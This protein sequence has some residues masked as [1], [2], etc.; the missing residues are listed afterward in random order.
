[1]LLPKRYGIDMETEIGSAIGATVAVAGRN[2]AGSDGWGTTGDSRTGASSDGGV[3][4]EHA[5]TRSKLGAA[6]RDHVLPDVTRD[7]LTVLRVGVREN[8]LDQV[9]AVLITG[10]VDQGD[11]RTI[12]ATLTNS[13]EVATKEINT[14]NLQ[15]LL[16]NLGG[17]LVHAVLGRVANDVV[18]CTAA[19]SWSA[20][21]A[22]V[23]NAPVAE[24]SVGNNVDARKNFLD[25]GSLVR[26]S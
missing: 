10:N 9:V 24:L 14:T 3:G 1:M 6:Q 11:A 12:V 25:A 21:L 20:M 19:I 7:H 22:D 2:T 4:A 13:V 5:D 17:K 16:D 23:L 18:N 15:A 26:V 8:V